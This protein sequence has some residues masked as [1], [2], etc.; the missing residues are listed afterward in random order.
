MPPED[1]ETRDDQLAG[2]PEAGDD[3]GDDEELVLGGGDED[4]DDDDDEEADPEALAAAAAA[5][6]LV[7]LPIACTNEGKGAPLSMGIQRWWA[8]ELATRGAKAAAPVFTA[9]AQQ[10]NRQVPAL[11]VFWPP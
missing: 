2:A 1:D 3:D 9:M 11:M 4:D 10:G 5:I 7:V 6:E 8:Q